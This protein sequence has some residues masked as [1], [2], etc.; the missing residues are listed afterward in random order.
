MGQTYDDRQTT[1]LLKVSNLLLQAGH[2][3]IKQHNS[4]QGGLGAAWGRKFD[5]KGTATV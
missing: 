4:K 3:I 2:L 5:I 1:P